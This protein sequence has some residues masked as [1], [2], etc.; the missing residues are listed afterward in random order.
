MIKTSDRKNSC[1]NSGHIHEPKKCPAFN[2]ACNKCK[3]L[4]YFGKFCESQKQSSK[5]MHEVTK[6]ESDW[7]DYSSDYRTGVIN[8]DSVESANK[9]FATLLINHKSVSLKLDSGAEINILTLAD[10]NKGCSQKA[11]SQ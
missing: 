6:H 7:S 10:F 9:E 11:E 8:C 1:R 4:G 5:F 3:R 2:K